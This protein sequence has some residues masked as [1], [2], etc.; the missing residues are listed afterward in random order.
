MISWYR[1]PI[2]LIV[3]LACI[4]VV[5]IAQSQPSST[6]AIPRLADGKPNLQGIW[7]VHNRAAYDLEDHH[8]RLGMPAGTSV[9]EGGTIPYQAWA[10]AKR[11]GHF[12]NRKMADPLAKC[13]MAGVPRIMYLNFPMQIFQNPRRVSILFEWSQNY[14]QIYTDGSKGPEGIE[15]WMGDSRGHWEGDTLVVDVTDHNDKAWFDMAGNFH[16]EAMQLRERFT[17]RD[18]DTIDYQVTVTDPKVFTRPWTMKMALYRNTE[19]SRV[20]EYECQAEAEEA[21]GAFPREPRTWY[22]E[23]R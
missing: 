6:T 7:Q 19:M 8:A 15:F 2:P 1:S 3:V 18:A 16:S 22:S 11:N 17:M 20:L 21:N 23:P 13:Y 14:R 12:A 9:V 10:L 5:L 4:S